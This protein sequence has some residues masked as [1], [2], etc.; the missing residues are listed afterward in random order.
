MARTGYTRDGRRVQ[1]PLVPGLCRPQG[2]SLNK[3]YH[4]KTSLLE[5]E[6]TGRDTLGHLPLRG[7]KL[8]SRPST[9]VSRA[10]TSPGDGDNDP[11][12]IR[13]D[14]HVLRFFGFVEEKTG[15]TFRSSATHIIRKVIV[16]FFL[17]DGTMKIVEPRNENSGIQ[18]GVMVSRQK[19]TKTG[20]PILR[21]AQ[22]D[23]DESEAFKPEEDLYIG[24]S[25][26]V[27][28]RQ[29]HLVDCDQW[30]RDYYDQE[31]TW[32]RDVLGAASQVQLCKSMIMEVRKPCPRSSW[33]RVG[34][35][36]SAL[37]R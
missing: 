8:Q 17:A 10:A 9:A 20:R 30:T 32:R 22:Q 1:I 16:Y 31:L 21:V 33:L 24:A 11:A 19:L 29:I 26:T 18:C 5:R 35:V 36:C 2:S 12:W 27:C 34:A 4:G 14:R 25:I 3:R 6:K 15:A 23:D 13:R 28:A 7:S 37:P